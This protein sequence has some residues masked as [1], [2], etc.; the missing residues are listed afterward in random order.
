M[1]V[2]EP[3][4]IVDDFLLGRGFFFGNPIPQSSINRIEAQV[5]IES[6]LIEHEWHVVKIPL[7]LK[8]V[9]IEAFKGFCLKAFKKLNPQDSTAFLV[10]AFRWRWY[11]ESGWQVTDHLPLGSNIC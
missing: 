7:G 10:K 4:V 9:G 2:I 1:I 5:I 6:N 11:D 3:Q 8:E